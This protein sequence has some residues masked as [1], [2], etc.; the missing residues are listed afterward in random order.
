MSMTG[1]PAEKA[2]RKIKAC[3]LVLCQ[4]S[5]SF[6]SNSLKIAFSGGADRQIPLPMALKPPPYD[7]FF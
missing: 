6:I 4:R 7:L 3:T 2:F 1:L 5:A